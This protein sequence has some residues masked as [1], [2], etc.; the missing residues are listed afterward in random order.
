MD[1]YTMFSSSVVSSIKGIVDI[2]TWLGYLDDINPK[3]YFS[4]IYFSLSYFLVFLV[5]LHWWNLVIYLR[6]YLNH[7][8]FKSRY[9]DLP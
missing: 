1:L 3:V 4:L 8:R 5:L 9:I 2:R 6:F 7:S